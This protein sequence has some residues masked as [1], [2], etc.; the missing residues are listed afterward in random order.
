MARFAALGMEIFITEM[1]V[2]IPENPSQGDLDNQANIYRQVMQKVLAEPAC[3]VV[4]VW[5]IPDKYSWVPD[6]FPGTGAPLLFDDNYN[7]KPCYYAVQDELG[8]ISPTPVPVN[9]GDV[10]NDGMIDIV[11][12]L[13]VAQY[14]VGLNPSNFNSSVADVNCDRSIDIVDALLIAQYYVGLLVSLDCQEFLLG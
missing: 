4:Q 14:Y 1:D 10:N 12:A 11:D 9:N 13:L 3:T 5:G 7:A 8:N 2:R 6:V